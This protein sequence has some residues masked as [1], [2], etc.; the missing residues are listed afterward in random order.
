M[1]GFYVAGHS[2]P[3]QS[4]QPISHQPDEA[5]KERQ[6]FSAASAL[7]GEREGEMQME[8]KVIRV[9][10]RKYHIE[11]ERQLEAAAEKYSARIPI[12]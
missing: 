3:I 9:G 1:I 11:N 12:N 7:G 4:H 2:T 10:A 8:W 5:N 6:L